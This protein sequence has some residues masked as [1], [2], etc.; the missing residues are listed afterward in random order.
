MPRPGDEFEFEF[1]NQLSDDED[2]DMLFSSNPEHRIGIEKIEGWKYRAF[3]K[4]I[5]INPVKVDC[6]LFVEEDVF[7]TN[8]PRVIGEFVGFTI[9]CL[10]GYGS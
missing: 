10:G 3:G 2:W 9:T 1:A 7:H 4:V 8:D 5:S 6:G